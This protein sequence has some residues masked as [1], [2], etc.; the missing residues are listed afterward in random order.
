MGVLE[1]SPTVPR[2]APGL[3][4]DQ[5]ILMKAAPPI[6]LTDDAP[7][8]QDIQ[9]STLGVRSFSQGLENYPDI[10][11]FQKIYVLSMP[12]RSDKRDALVL[13]AYLSG[14]ELEFIDGVDPATI[15][16]KAYPQVMA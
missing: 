7:N 11:Q 6:S 1:R 9:N 15:P 5:K 10:S 14:L 16:E 4:N 3:L 2:R 8:L 13:S 12:N